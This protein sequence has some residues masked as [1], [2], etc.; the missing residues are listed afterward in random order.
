EAF[1][2]AVQVGA[3]AAA[4]GKLVTFGI[5]PQSAHTGYGYIRAGRQEGA[6]HRVA[7]FVEKPDQ[8]TAEGYL[9]AGDYYWNSGMFLFRADRYLE[10]LARFRPDIVAACE[11][12]WEARQ[13]D[14]D[15]IRVAREAFAACPEDSIDYAVMEK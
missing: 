9:A 13:Q 11:A 10:E 4:E 3:D 6:W 1:V 14:M 5:V 7:E 15:F 2:R 12:A 8:V